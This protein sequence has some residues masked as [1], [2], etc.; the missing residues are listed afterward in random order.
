MI[1]EDWVIDSSAPTSKDASGIENNSLIVRELIA[2]EKQ[3]ADIMAEQDEK[4]AFHTLSSVGPEATTV[5]LAAAVPLENTG[6]TEKTN[7]TSLGA[8]EKLPYENPSAEKESEDVSNVTKFSEK[9][10]QPTPDP[11]SVPGFFPDTPA[12]EK[13]EEQTVGVNP[14]PASTGTGNPIDLK[15]GEAVPEQVQAESGTNVKLDEESYNNPD[16]S[17]FGVEDHNKT[18]GVNPLPAA[19][20]PGNPIDLKPGEPVP[21][22]FSATD[23]TA[24]NVKLDKESYEQ[25]DASNFGTSGAAPF[26]LPNP[27]TPPE[28]REKEG[29]GILPGLEKIVSDNKEEEFAP[30][31]PDV[32]KDS[33]DKANDEAGAAGV[34][35]SVEHKS[36]VESELVKTVS[37]EGAADGE[38]VK[39]VPEVVRESLHQAHQSPEAAANEAAV[40]QK[41]AVEAQL[42]KTVSAEAKPEAADA[43]PEVV[44]KSMGEVNKSPEAA[45]S[46]DAVE[47]KKEF[48]KEL[49]RTVSNGHVATAT[50]QVPEVV[51]DSLTQADKEPEA[52]S[53]AAAVENKSK[54]ES[55]LAAT[56]Q[57]APAIEPTEEAKGD[58]E[59]KDVVVPKKSSEEDKSNKSTKSTESAKA[60]QSTESSRSKDD[61]KEKRGSRWFGKLRSFF[62]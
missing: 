57:R 36:A 52:A 42:V 40:E 48:E 49:V 11:K 61:K 35:E 31:V 43:V 58:A 21:E 32:V 51:K 41:E 17:N 53:N 60:K 5:Q 8:N 3:P 30:A 4:A 33:I 54:V 22:Q 6:E 46:A 47:H 59:K 56:K 39:S 19:A 24:S 23:D 1:N 14:L 13:K 55:E 26:S 45:A 34:P 37:N 12:W 44:K 7:N 2:K 25:A 18:F 9:Q 28:D 15:P 27:V 20:G 16:A 38:A 29:R 10:D 62:H 50:S